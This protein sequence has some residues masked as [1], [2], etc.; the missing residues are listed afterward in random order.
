M[1]QLPKCSTAKVGIYIHA[2]ARTFHLKNP[3]SQTESILH[4]L[5]L[6]TPWYQAELILNTY[7]RVWY[8]MFQNLLPYFQ[9]LAFQKF[10]VTPSNQDWEQKL[11]MWPLHCVLQK[12]N[13]ILITLFQGIVN[14][15]RIAGINFSKYP[16]ISVLVAPSKLTIQETI[17]IVL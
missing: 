16:R 8:L 13:P 1:Q 15:T 10:P 4:N 5:F 12:D 14:F 6:L 17:V 2:T 9:L 3:P 7:Q 11:Q